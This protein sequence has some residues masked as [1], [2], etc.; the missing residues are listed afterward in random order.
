MSNNYMYT[1]EEH[2]ACGVGFVA[3]LDA[4]PSRAVV[5]DAI[6][7]LGRMAHRGG[8][9]CGPE[10]ADGAGVLLPLPRSFMQR[11]WQPFCP[12]LP[13]QYGVGHFFLPQDKALR[14]ELE[15][16]V[17]KIFSQHS[18][19]AVAWRDT[20]VRDELLQEKAR[21]VRPVIRQLLLTPQGDQLEEAADFERA[22]Y[23]TRRH[24][25]Q[26]V[27]DETLCPP[28]AFHV[29]SLSSHTIVYKGMLP[30]GK[31]AA[32]YPDLANRDFTAHFAIFHERFSTNTQPAWRLAQPFRCL[33]HN[34]EIN[35]LHCNQ[36][37]M[38]AREPLL[39]SPLFGE[40]NKY[41][42]PALERSGSDSAMLDNAL[43]LL[44]QG[45]RSLPHAAMMLVPEAFGSAFIM[46]EDKR[47]FYEYH[48]AFM[49]P[50]DGPSALVFTDGCRQIGAMLDRNALRPC[51]YVTTKDGLF[52][53][54]SEAGVLD[55][56]ES[57][58]AKRGRLQPRRMLLVDF[59]RH[60]VITDAEC[61]GRV[62][63]GKPYR[64]WVREKAITLRDL[65]LP[66]N[67]CEAHATASGHNTFPSDTP[68]GRKDN[69][70]PE[71]SLLRQQHLY[72]FSKEEV[73]DILIPMGQ[74]AQEPIASMGQDTPLAVLSQEPQLLF[75][76]LKQRF[77]QVTNPPIDPLREGL[78]MTLTGFAGRRGNL[79]EE[80]PEHYSLLRLAN[81]LLF[82]ED[83][84]RLE[85]SQNPHVR[86]ATIPILFP[87]RQAT[88]E[89][90][91][92]TSEQSIPPT[93]YGAVLEQALAEMCAQADAA[94]RPE[95]SGNSVNG[96]NGATL[97][98]LSD[99]GADADHAPIPSLLAVSALH[100]HLLRNKL[101]HACGILVDTGE[102]RE[103]MH[104]AQLIAFG[105]S[106]VHPRV[107]FATLDALA[108][109]GKLGANDT[110]FKAH[111]AYATA[112][113]KGLLKT[114]SRMGISTLR[115]FMGGQGFEALGLGDE[116]IKRYFTGLP[117]RIGGI[118][119][120]EIAADALAR[121]RAA[122]PL[123]EAVAVSLSEQAEAQTVST[124]SSASSMIVAS[125]TLRLPP[126]TDKGKHRHRNGGEKHLWSP[127]AIR[128]LHKAVRDNDPESY[129]IYADESD[130]QCDR[131]VTLRA[132]LR[133][134][135]GSVTPV[136]LSEVETESA[137]LRRFVGAAMSLGSISPEAHAAI[138]IA[139]NRVGGRS[140]S[141]EGGEAPERL[142]P[143]P[144]GDNARSRIR[145][146][147]SGR[148]GVTATYLTQADEI[149]IK[150]AQGAKPGEGGQL[151]AHKVLPEIAR[152]RHTI[153]GVT[154]ISPPPH[155][156]I[157][158]I[159]DLAQLIYDLK[160]LHP[161]VRISVKL[162]AGTQLGPIA[163]GVAKAGADSILISGH[164]GG[165]GASPRSAIAHVGLPW[166]LGLAETQATLVN[167]GLRGRVLLQ[168]DGQLRT[169]KDLAM[170]AMLGA[171][172]F[173]FGA[174]L[175]VA[176]G[177]CMLRVCHLGT[178]SVGIATQ[179]LKLRNRFPGKPEHVE[180]FL[181]FLAADLRSH[182]ARLGFRGVDEMIGRADLLEP[183]PLSA[184]AVS[185]PSSGEC[186]TTTTVVAASHT[187]RL[188][189]LWLRK[190]ASL[191]LRPLLTR[192][193]PNSD[194]K[195]ESTVLNG[196]NPV[197]TA[198]CE[199]NALPES[200]LDTAM[201]AA[202]LPGVRAASPCRFEGIVHNTDRAVCAALSGEIA[203]LYPE[204]GLPSG[205][206]DITLR[207]SAGQ[208]AGAFLMHGITLNIK[209]EANDYVG[210]GLSGG[211][212][213]VAPVNNETSQLP[214]LAFEQAVIGNVALYGATSGEAYFAGTAGE[215]FAVRNSGAHAVVE[216]V[217]DHACEYMT[218]G[219]V[220]VLGSTG[221]NFAAGMSGGVAYVF[222]R[223]E[224]FQ[225]RCNMDGV[226]L[227]SVWQQ[228]DVMLLRSLLTR[229]VRYTG[230]LLAA[231]ILEDWNA[232]LPLFLKAT[233]IEYQRALARMKQNEGTQA[234]SI[235]ATEEVY[236]P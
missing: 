203:R 101:R 143:L 198:A 38:A 236:H 171:D 190:L 46:G 163:S 48:A 89:L 9:G 32:F 19:Q 47:A 1:P 201:L 26:V 211:V 28:G 70:L 223:S 40:Y 131:P 202:V 6:A 172:E 136:P 153:P 144:N 197:S 118:G 195:N 186:K 188:G 76:Y 230:S 36:A 220:V 214:G 73:S 128:A 127:T 151:P 182:M 45:G 103:V 235:A 92:Q 105:A 43:E 130:R 114:F 160:R 10:N 51:R 67:A 156:D 37:A 137:I 187:A 64:H 99:A 138:A 58:I 22:L 31:L 16:L 199:S 116:L 146:I 135:E 179:D 115:S 154:L 142:L 86:M 112:I 78:V 120:E 158:S 121:H 109:S 113:Q 11:V 122:Y 60:R 221:Y 4:A 219:V 224:R 129:R 33:A 159:E 17:E 82:P 20:P 193:S 100:H 205:S 207:G 12:I 165:T 225:T 185:L 34:G 191:N 178:C 79:L 210:K 24:L 180:N 97:I 61:K 169:G 227:E 8:S 175:L 87:V 231:S 222:D 94:L 42:T 2:D 21:K 150:M 196:N 81:P 145:Q 83:I 44:I 167:N 124:L 233:P 173:G 71:N 152:V 213:A 140:N 204:I 162:V 206:V 62:I 232:S 192:T 54:A 69:E 95:S 229:H 161:S 176:L 183:A 166:E 65:P 63:Y 164:D 170:A 14:T 29:A 147:A 68:A 132:L 126:L 15:T 35:T 25:E 18:I 50:W 41:I 85:A 133:F 107:A 217:G 98:L 30:G 181:R 66:T 228:Q 125:A 13:E 155:H 96:K 52:L 208:S 123:T 56:P 106:A 111:K 117:S 80:T 234:E 157:Y 102:A 88:E 3:R 91:R 194:N 84:K 168:T 23:L 5:E 77:A 212:I 177:C 74:N 148:F 149:Q 226:D 104:L 189:E 93:P 90:T 218:G 216:G 59:A 53:L 200:A 139:F 184:M 134:A 110:A 57:R 75:S 108:A 27:R 174:S 209:G 215:R 39:H 55:L 49:E 119:L 7:A 141:G 72:G